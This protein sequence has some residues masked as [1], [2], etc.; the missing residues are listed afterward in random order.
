MKAPAFLLLLLLAVPAPAQEIRGFWVDGFA[1]GFKTSEQIDLLLDRV[2]KANMNAVFVQ[3]RKSADSY[4]QSRY[5]IWATDNA[6]R[7]DALKVL[8]EKAHSG[9]PRIQIHAWMNTF[10][11]GKDRGNPLHVTLTHPEWL[12][13]SDA[14]ETHDGEATKLDPGHPEAA[15]YTARV[16]LDV[17]RNYGVDGIHFDFV[18]YG[19]P[20]WGY[21]PVSVSRFNARYGREGLPNSTDPLWKQWRRD[22][23]T[24]LVRKVYVMAASVKPGVQV[25]A[26]TITWQEGPRNQAEWIG[27]SAAMNRVFQDW[28]AWMKEGIIDLNCLM[29]YYDDRKRGAWYRRWIEFAKENQFGRYVAPAAG[30]WLNTIPGSFAQ[31][32]AIRNPAPS[33]ARSKGVMLYSYAGTNKG[34]DGLEQRFNPDFYD[35]LSRPSR[36]TQNSPFAKPASYPQMPWK[37]KPKTGCIM[38]FAYH[39]AELL[40]MDGA[41][42][43]ITGKGF[44]RSIRTD[45][46]GFYALVGLKPGEYAVSLVESPGRK[47]RVTVNAGKVAE[48][49]LIRPGNASAEIKNLEDLKAIGPFSPVTLR[50][51]VVLVGTDT[52]PGKVLVTDSH[53]RM[54]VR[55]QLAESPLLA[56]QP[57]DVIAVRGHWDPSSGE[58]VLDN[59]RA[60]ITGIEPAPNLARFARRLEGRTLDGGTGRL[61][62]GTGVVHVGLG[63]RK[64]VSIEDPSDEIPW[65]AP[66]STV[67]VS[68]LMCPSAEAM[69]FRKTIYPLTP[70]SVQVIQS[71]TANL[72]MKLGLWACVALAASAATFALLRLR[73]THTNRKRVKY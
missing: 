3:V 54:L 55:I 61:E 71:S 25:S 51:A 68:G 4:Y 17:V 19:G 10:A 6:H 30:T 44:A 62:T 42:V 29:S 18:R 1:E 73:A 63:V 21:N 58:P 38:G 57:G 47:T 43:K 32:A 45:G 56:L 34:P 31:I 60:R 72:L 65:P 37:A 12:S 9:R 27:K 40:P 49:A 16:Y 46:T 52:M 22:Q 8:I 39:G 36:F 24:A 13:I 70:D 41:E 2:R 35:A 53:G 64:G 14:G 67:V 66:E 15:D 33:G 59:A 20:R 7:F 23:V 69:G 48:A 50:G 5:D 28:R 26:A 11:V